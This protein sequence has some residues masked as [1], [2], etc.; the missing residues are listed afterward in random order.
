MKITS[1]QEFGSDT[2]LF[3][4]NQTGNTPVHC[5]NDSQKANKK[6]KKTNANTTTNPS[7][8][9][10]SGYDDIPPPEKTTLQTEE[11]P[12]KNETTNGL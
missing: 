1:L 10:Y 12:A 11:R 5:F 8:V 4:R 7:G 9:N 3:L 6:S 2:E